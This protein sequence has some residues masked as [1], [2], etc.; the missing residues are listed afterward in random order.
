M[1]SPHGSAVVVRTD[2]VRKHL[3]GIALTARAG[4]GLDEGLYAPEMGERTYAE[5]LRLARE[6]LTAGWSAVIDG[7][8]ATAATRERARRVSHDAGAPFTV[9]W[10]DAPDAVLVERLR[11]RERERTE[12]SDAG[13][14]FLAAH[15]ERY[16]APADE[17]DVVELDTSRDTASLVERAVSRRA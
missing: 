3:A 9:L 6:L 1:R 17:A 10:C 15:R 2:A 12:V 7:A 16:E 11:R 5:A 13:A 8:F 4:A 14:D